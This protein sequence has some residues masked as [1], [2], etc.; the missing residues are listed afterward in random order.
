MPM[1][2]SLKAPMSWCGKAPPAGLLAGLCERGAAPGR[3]GAG[4]DGRV[5]GLVVGDLSGGSP[6]CFFVDD[7]LAGCVGGDER[8]DGDVVDGAGVAARGVV[9]ERCGV[10]GEQGV[11]SPGE[12][13]VVGEVAG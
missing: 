5:P 9:D 8:C 12:L 4:L 7:G 1:K 3:H 11:G 10:A 6:G 13:D 2:A